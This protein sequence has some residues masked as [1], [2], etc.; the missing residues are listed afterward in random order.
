MDAQ[1]KLVWDADISAAVLGRGTDFVLIP[2]SHKEDTSASEA[3]ARERGFSFCG[4]LGY[5]ENGRT[6]A[7]CEPNEDPDLALETVVIMASAVQT[8]AEY[9]VAKLKVRKHA[10]F[11][12]R[13]YRLPQGPRT[14]GDE[15]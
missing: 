12:G 1:Q 9:V 2:I 14:P 15:N 7:K 4:V 8:F 10:E 3:L 11:R 13:V 6:E 5:F